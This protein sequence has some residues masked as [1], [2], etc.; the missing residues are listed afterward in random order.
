MPA[1]GKITGSK[2]APYGAKYTFIYNRF[3]NRDP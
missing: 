2:Y 3:S 1:L